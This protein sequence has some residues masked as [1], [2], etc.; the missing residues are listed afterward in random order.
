MIIKYNV[1]DRRESFDELDFWYNYWQLVRRKQSAQGFFD[2]GVEVFC[3]VAGKEMNPSMKRLFSDRE[4]NWV[5]PSPTQV[6]ALLGM[7]KS[8]QDVMR[9]LGYRGIGIVSNTWYKKGILDIVV[10]NRLLW[11]LDLKNRLFKTPVEIRD[12]NIGD[13]FPYRNYSHKKGT[14]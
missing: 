13:K 14:I 1:E 10:W 7:C 12:F 9:E 11:L 4:V 8:Q 2:D 5:A 3:V 6:R